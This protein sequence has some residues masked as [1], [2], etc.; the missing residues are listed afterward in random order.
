[1]TKEEKMYKELIDKM[2]EIAGHEVIYED[3]KDRKD[4]WYEAW[5]MTEDQHI[6]W[7]NWGEAYIKKKKRCTVP[8]ARRTMSYFALNY[9][10]KFRDNEEPA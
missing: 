5:T 10:L 4:N 6:E 2:F 8:L 3:I 9:G 1:M 7:V